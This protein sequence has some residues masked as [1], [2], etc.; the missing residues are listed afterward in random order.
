MMGVFDMRRNC[1]GAFRT[2]FGVG[3]VELR[4]TVCLK[5][6]SDPKFT[7]AHNLVPG[8]GFAPWT[9]WLSASPTQKIGKS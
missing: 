2:L 9:P 1:S 6:A 4:T 5:S 8:Q 3:P 7:R